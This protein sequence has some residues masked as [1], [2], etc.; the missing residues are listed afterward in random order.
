MALITL[1]RIAASSILRFQHLDS[2]NT[3]CFA[4]AL[5]FCS[6]GGRKFC[7]KR[8]ASF[9]DPKRARGG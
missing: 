5:N 9:D 8:A 2:K 3:A 1:G 7:A 4:L 6:S